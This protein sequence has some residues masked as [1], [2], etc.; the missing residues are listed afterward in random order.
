MI[1]LIDVERPEQPSIASKFPQK[2]TCAWEGRV[3]WGEE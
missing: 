2:F 3:R 1:I